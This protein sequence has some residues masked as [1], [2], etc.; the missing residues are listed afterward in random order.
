MSERENKSWAVLSLGLMQRN[1]S[2]KF[3]SWRSAG[4]RAVRGWGRGGSPDTAQ[5]P[6][7]TYQARPRHVPSDSRLTP[8][9]G[10]A[11][12]L[13]PPP[14]ASGLFPPSLRFS[15]SAG[16]PFVPDF[17]R[18]FTS[19]MSGGPQEKEGRLYNLG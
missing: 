9:R 14:R 1:R 19:D 12:P 11:Q 17:F 5:R 8:V 7:T 3:G 10:S 6:Q 13:P 18:L 4:C 15:G 2:G 16:A